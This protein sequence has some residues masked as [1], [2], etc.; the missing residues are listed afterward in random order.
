M[1]SVYILKSLKDGSFYIGCTSN[2]PERIKVHNSGKTR[3]LKHKRPLEIVYK[4]DYT[5]ATEAFVREKQIKSY[6]GGNAFKK[7]IN[8]L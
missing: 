5:N 1:Y 7:L 4:E 2:L 8:K 3:S 6:K